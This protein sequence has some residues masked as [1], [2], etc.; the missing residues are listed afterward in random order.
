V[1]TDEAIAAIPTGWRIYTIDMSIIDRVAVMLSQIDH[2][3]YVS[4]VAPTI[5]DAVAAASAKAKWHYRGWT[6][7]PAY[8]GYEASHPDYDYCVETGGNGLA[9]H[10]MTV[11]QVR[12]EI[13]DKE[14]EGR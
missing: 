14:E 7:E 12:A 2:I 6:I 8:I 10:G 1:T 9:V 11:E 4:G 3:G 5:A 13:D